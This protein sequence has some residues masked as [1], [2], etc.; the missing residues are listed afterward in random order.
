MEM[1]TMPKPF[2][3]GASDTGVPLEAGDLLEPIMTFL[4]QSGMSKTNLQLECQTAI[5]SATKKKSK[6]RVVHVGYTQE[7]ISAVNRWLR[8]P[9]YLNRMGKPGDLSLKGSR[10][11]GSLV[12]ACHLDAAPAAVLEQLLE[13]GVVKKIASGKYRLIKRLMDFGQKHYV[14]FEPNFRFLV[15][16]TRAATSKLST[17]RTP[18]ILFWQ[19]AD[20]FKIPR[21]HMRDFMRF[22][23]QRGL[24][25]MYEINDWLDQHESRESRASINRTSVR[26]FGVGLFGISSDR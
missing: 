14:P 20:N 19:C 12:K 13:F 25:F 9:A 7:A 26:R 2:T 21:H 1:L 10:S 5:N 24:S 18:P 8:D 6:R 3:E 17:T 23:H 22:A 11:F 15:D 4:R 16:A